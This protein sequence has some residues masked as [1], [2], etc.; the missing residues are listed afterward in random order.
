MVHWKLACVILNFHIWVQ[1]PIVPKKCL[2]CSSK[3]SNFCLQLVKLLYGAL[4]L[5]WKNSSLN[6]SQF[7]FG[8]LFGIIIGH[9]FN[10]GS[11]FPPYHTQIKLQ[12][13]IGRR[14][15]LTLFGKIEKLRGLIFYPWNINGAKRGL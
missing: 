14:P 3:Y 4:I 13:L 9:N 2:A 5:N 10:L 7:D 11:L 12:K 15:F 6:L 8:W 1:M